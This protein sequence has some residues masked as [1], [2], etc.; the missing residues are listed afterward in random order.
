[1]DGLHSSENGELDNGKNGEPPCQHTPCYKPL[2][3]PFKS[4]PPLNSLMLSL[5]ML[6]R[7][8]MSK[9]VLFPASKV[10]VFPL[11]SQRFKKNLGLK[12]Q[13]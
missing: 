9:Q 10:G 5:I 6:K 11:T 7:E 12:L 4:P 3:I 8:T 13:C 1:M 2:S